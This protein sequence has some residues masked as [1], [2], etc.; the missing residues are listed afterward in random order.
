MGIKALYKIHD[1]ILHFILD[2]YLF[3]VMFAKI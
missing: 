3:F 1:N 2:F